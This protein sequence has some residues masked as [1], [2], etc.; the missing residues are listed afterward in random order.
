MHE[1]KNV[2][3]SL[4]SWTT[5][6]DGTGEGCDYIMVGPDNEIA[7]YSRIIGAGYSCGFPST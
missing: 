6:R 1:V 4:F 7:F 5:P 3:E 2:D